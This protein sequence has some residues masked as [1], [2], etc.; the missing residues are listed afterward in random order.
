[1]RFNY[2][3]GDYLLEADEG[4]TQITL[5]EYL[6]REGYSRGFFDDYLFVRK[7]NG[8]WGAKCRV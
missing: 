7:A 6:N 4:E 8:Q 1:M 2:Y 5:E 3:A